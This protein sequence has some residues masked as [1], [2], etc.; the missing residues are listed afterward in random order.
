MLL[1]RKSVLVEIR[2]W[3][4]VSNS[5]SVD[6]DDV[7]EQK[8]RLELSGSPGRKADVGRVGKAR[9]A[10]VGEWEVK[11]AGKVEHRNNNVGGYPLV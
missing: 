8:E 4:S 2:C 5:P 11:K 10:R 7:A 3:N 1:V 6:L 9:V